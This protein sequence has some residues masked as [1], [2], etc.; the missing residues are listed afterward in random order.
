VEQKSVKMA[1]TDIYNNNVWGLGSGTGSLPENNLVYMNYLSEFLKKNNVKSVVDFGCGDWQFSRYIDWTGVNYLGVD[2]VDSV[3]QA[4]NEKF[5]NEN[6]S[7]QTVPDLADLPECDLIISKDVLQHLPLGDIHANLAAL[8]AKSK[9]MLITNDVYP[10]K[11]TNVEIEPGGCRS[12]RFDLPPFSMTA[13]V[14]FSWA[15]IS[16]GNFVEKRTYLMMGD[17]MQNND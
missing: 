1:F 17:L 11:W 10:D 13:P 3:V 5:A 16:Y 2:V 8:R 12:L 9:Y 15:F 6:I 14:V 4:N 7:F